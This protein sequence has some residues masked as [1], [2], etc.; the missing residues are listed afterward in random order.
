MQRIW[1]CCTSAERV[2]SAP[3]TG[4]VTSQSRDRF[5]SLAVRW[6]RGACAGNSFRALGTRCAFVGFV[7]MCALYTSCMRSVC[8]LYTRS[9]LATRCAFVV[10]SLASPK[11]WQKLG[12]QRR[13]D[14]NFHFLINFQCA[15]RASRM[16]DR[17]IIA[18]EGFDYEQISTLLGAQGPNPEPVLGSFTCITQH[19]GPTALRPIRK[20]MQLWLSVLLKDTST[21]TGQASIR[22][23]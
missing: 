7:Y 4:T 8:A 10:H 11:F 14:L 21:A 6:A 15:G 13:T 23:H 9:A 5:R 19:T 1:A 17:A 3:S 20:T 16:C 12:A 2:S 18:G 22:T